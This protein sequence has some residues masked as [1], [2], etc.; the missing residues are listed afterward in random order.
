MKSEY[1]WEQYNEFWEEALTKVVSNQFLESVEK[2]ARY[3]GEPFSIGDDDV[4]V[5][6]Q[7]ELRHTSYIKDFS[8]RGKKC[9]VHTDYDIT[10]ITDVATTSDYNS[11]LLVAEIKTQLQFDQS[12]NEDNIT[13]NPPELYIFPVKT[14]KQLKTGYLPS[15]DEI[16]KSF[17]TDQNKYQSLIYNFCNTYKLVGYNDVS[18]RIHTFSVVH[19]ALLLLDIDEE[20]IELSKDIKVTKRTDKEGRKAAHERLMD[21]YIKNKNK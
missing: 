1:G 8:H 4:Y 15:L 14:G 6:S 11:F 3:K 5:K 21:F 13:A 16:K 12:I 18:D 7:G 17:N 20:A 2:W 19:N 10:Q 9:H